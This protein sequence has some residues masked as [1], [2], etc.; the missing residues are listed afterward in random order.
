MQNVYTL[1]LWVRTP[2][3]ILPT[4][5]SFLRTLRSPVSRGLIGRSLHSAATFSGISF[6]IMPEVFNLRYKAQPRLWESGTGGVF[7]DESFEDLKRK[8]E[9]DEDYCLS[10]HLEN[11]HYSDCIETLSFDVMKP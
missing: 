11:T 10:L 3:V 8:L 2:F 9:I 6:F 7:L 4:L 1:D 5:A